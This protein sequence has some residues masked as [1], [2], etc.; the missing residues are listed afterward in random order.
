[1]DTQDIV[2]YSFVQKYDSYSGQRLVCFSSPDKPEPLTQNANVV[3]HPCPITSVIDFGLGAD[4]SLHMVNL[5]TE[6][7]SDNNTIDGYLENI[8]NMMQS[9]DILEFLSHILKN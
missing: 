2:G 3:S 5:A 6:H 7:V 1:M 8:G 9:M 4:R